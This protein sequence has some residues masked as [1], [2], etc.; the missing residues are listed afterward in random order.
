MTGRSNRIVSA[1]ASQQTLNAR[2][3]ASIERRLGE[4]VGMAEQD[5]GESGLVAPL[6]GLGR[7][8]GRGMDEA[9]NDLAM[10]RARGLARAWNRAAGR[11]VF[12]VPDEV[13]VGPVLGDLRGRDMLQPAERAARAK[14][15]AGVRQATTETEQRTAAKAGAKLLRNGLRTMA[16]TA[17]NRVQNAAALAVMA[18]SPEV[19]AVAAVVILDERTSDICLGLAGGIWDVVSG[20]PTA[21][22][23]VL[24]PFPGPPPYHYHCRTGLAPVL[25]S[26]EPPTLESMED[27]INEHPADAMSALGEDRVDLWRRGLLPHS[28]LVDQSARPI[29]DMEA[30]AGEDAAIRE[31]GNLEPRRRR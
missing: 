9:L 6:V 29:D 19:E 4:V 15:A 14:V 8:L 16:V 1:T 21:Q 12:G 20:Q 2:R 24:D 7:K 23:R 31:A 25:A 17:A 27:W 13:K 30:A 11:R 5:A 10:E 18:T 22:S 3:L 26:H 28:Q